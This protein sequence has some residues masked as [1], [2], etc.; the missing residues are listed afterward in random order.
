MRRRILLFL[1]NSKIQQMVRDSR[2]R[3]FARRN[4]KLDVVG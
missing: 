3:L 1:E 4:I 2:D